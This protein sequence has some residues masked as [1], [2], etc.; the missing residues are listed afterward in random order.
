MVVPRAPPDRAAASSALDQRQAWSAGAAW[1]CTRLAADSSGKG[2]GAQGSA[3]CRVGRRNVGPEPASGRQA[4]YQAG[5]R[6]AA[7]AGHPDDLSAG[8]AEGLGRRDRNV[9]GPATHSA[10]LVEG[11]WADQSGALPEGPRIPQTGGA[12]S[13]VADSAASSAAVSEALRPR[14]PNPQQAVRSPHRDAR[15]GLPDQCCDHQRESPAPRV[16]AVSASALD[17]SP[18]AKDQWNRRRCWIGYW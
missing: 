9:P 6:S 10:S 1:W 3:P 18:S 11:H 8:R 16:V 17:G 5:A 14:S 4:P 12:D 7:Q 2:P 13:G 15:A